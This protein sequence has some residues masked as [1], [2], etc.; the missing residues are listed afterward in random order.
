MAIK[1]AP[2]AVAGE[3]TLPDLPQDLDDLFKL[4]DITEVKATGA[5]PGTIEGIF[6]MPLISEDARATHLNNTALLQEVPDSPPKYT[7]RSDGMLAAS[8]KVNWKPIHR[9]HVQMVV[10]T[11]NDTY[12]QAVAAHLLSPWDEQHRAQII[13]KL[14]DSKALLWQRTASTTGRFYIFSQA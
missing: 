6:D 12:D 4:Y 7:S 1:V 3:A 8:I 13:E 9:A 10:A 14:V 2:G 5:V 11:P